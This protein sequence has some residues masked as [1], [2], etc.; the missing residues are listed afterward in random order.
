MNDRSRCS[1]AV[2]Q[3]CRQLLR[4]GRRPAYAGK[5]LRYSHAEGAGLV[6]QVFA[7]RASHAHVVPLPPADEALIAIIKVA[8]WGIGCI[9]S[10]MLAMQSYGFGN[11]ASRFLN[12]GLTL[13]NWVPSSRM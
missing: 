12:P 7:F 5:V 1:L 6:A 4:Y 2:A 3:E 8:D 9:L 10:G 13:T 11:D